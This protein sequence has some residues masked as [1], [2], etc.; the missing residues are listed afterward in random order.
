[1]AVILIQWILAN[2][3]DVCS[4]KQVVEM[5]FLSLS[6]PRLKQKVVPRIIFTWPLIYS[7]ISEQDPIKPPFTS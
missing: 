2:K 3:L 4:T 6:F 7:M 5:M 1:M